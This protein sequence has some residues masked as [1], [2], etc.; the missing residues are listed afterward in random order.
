MPVIAES[1]PL[2]FGG[3]PTPSRTPT[4]T[5]TPAPPTPFPTNSPAP[6]TPRPLDFV[7]RHIQFIDRVDTLSSCFIR[8][9][10]PDFTDKEFTEHYAVAAK[11]K[12]LVKEQNMICSM[13]GINALTRT[14]K[15]LGEE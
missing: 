13:Q 3:T 8:S 12:Y 14:L 4:P 11:D 15:R 9:D 6:I 2:I 10:L 5:R 7:A 1:P